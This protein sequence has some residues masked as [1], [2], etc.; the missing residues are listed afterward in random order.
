[1]KRINIIEDNDDFI[2]INKSAN[3][4][5]HNEETLDGLFTQLKTELGYDIWPVHRLDKLTSG[6]LIFA[7]SKNSAASFGKLFE[8]KAIKKVYLVS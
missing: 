7:K 1:M 5:F 6:L 4:S 8:T 2:I 3:I